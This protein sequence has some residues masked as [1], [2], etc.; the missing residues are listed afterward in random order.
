MI[1]LLPAGLQITALEFGCRRH[2]KIMTAASISCCR[3]TFFFF[4]G[5]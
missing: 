4:F 1:K 5:I 2:H 3:H